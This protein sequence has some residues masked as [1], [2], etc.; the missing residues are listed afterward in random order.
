MQSDIEAT[1]YAA[2]QYLE[3]VLSVDEETGIG[4]GSKKRASLEHKD[5]Y[6]G[7]PKL[8]KRSGCGTYLQNFSKDLEDCPQTAHST[9]VLDPNTWLVPTLPPLNA[10]VSV[11]GL[12]PERLRHQLGILLPRLVV[13][14]LHRGLDVGVAHPFLYAADV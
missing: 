3:C 14:V 2:L 6:S 8:F 1:P 11:N 4:S 12:D 9:R 10:I 5:E 13:E 7:L